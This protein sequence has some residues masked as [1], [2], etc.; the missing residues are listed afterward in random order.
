MKREVP[1]E[2]RSKEG[3]K[4]LA[5]ELGI[6]NYDSSPEKNTELLEK[7]KAFR[8]KPLVEEEA[9]IINPAVRTRRELPRIYNF[10]ESRFKEYNKAKDKDAYKKNIENKI[11][12]GSGMPLI[13]GQ[14]GG[15]FTNPFEE[16][17]KRQL[18]RK[19]GGQVANIST[20]VLKKL[21][22][23]GAKFNIL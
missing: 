18:R 3:R 15:G 12:F 14:Y 21:Q 4:K 5:E 8:E 22:A 9:E 6:E 16:K 1:D 2:D 20:E 11:R 13:K 7:Y 17:S 10:S 23:K 19:K